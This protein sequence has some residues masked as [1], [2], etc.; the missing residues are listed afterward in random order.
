MTV[1]NTGNVRVI[2]P[3]LTH[4][5]QGYRHQ[6][7]VGGL[8]FPRVPVAVSG[9]KVLQFG[10]ESFQIYNARRAPGGKVKR[11]QFGYEGKPFALEQDAL[12]GKVPVEWMRDAK[13]VP[14]IDLGQRAVNNVM[15]ILGLSLEIQQAEIATTSAN[16]D[17]D[18]KVALSGGDKWSA[19]TG[20]PVSD[21]GTGREAV[22]KSTGLYPNIAILSPDAWNAAK[23]NPQVLERRKYVEKG[24]VT[25]AEFAAIVEVEAVVV[26]KAVYHDGREFQDV[27]GNNAVLAYAPQTPGG[28]EEPS[29]GY[30][31]AM[32]GHPVVEQAYWAADEKSWIYPC[33]YER[34]P[35][36]TGMVAG[37]LIQTPA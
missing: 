22:R 10:P 29:Y 23:E 7:R 15:S 34:A 19:D 11:V 5:A 31:Y 6:E 32:D 3:I 16:Y 25:L 37:F 4:H 18:H 27:W 9:G 8:L 21:F 36:L 2:D 13:A 17:A 20:K 1:L 30:T 12:E 24:P 35:V 28:M 14:G 33:T 26:G